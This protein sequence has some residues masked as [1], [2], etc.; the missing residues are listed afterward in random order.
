M[1]KIVCLRTPQ[2][3]LKSVFDITKEGVSPEEEGNFI[4][5]TTN[6]KNKCICLC[7]NLT[8]N[9]HSSVYY[10]KRHIKTLMH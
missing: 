7:C 2:E 9:W 1:S 4:L 10:I 6:P 5:E 3:I 8:L